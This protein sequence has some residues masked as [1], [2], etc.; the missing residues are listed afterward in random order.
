LDF[1]PKPKWM[2]WATYR[3]AEERF[4]RYQTILDGD[5]SIG[6]IPAVRVIE[7]VKLRQVISIPNGTRKDQHRLGLFQRVV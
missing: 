5:R 2:R 6:K 3:R 4:D 7:I 1:A